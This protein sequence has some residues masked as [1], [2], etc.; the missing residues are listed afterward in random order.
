M[1]V[2][3]IP[4]RFGEGQRLIGVLSLPEQA[5]PG[6]P[7]LLVPN[8]GIEHRV[9]PNR[10]HVEGAR[11]L[12]AEGWT[13]LRVDLAGMGDSEPA[14]GR[15]ADAVSDLR[16]AA[17][18]IR[19]RGLG[20]RCIVLG[21]CSGAHDAH[22]FAL[23]DPRVVGVFLIDGYAYPTRRF[24]RIRLWQRL[25][26]VHRLLA[27]KLRPTAGMGK[28]KEMFYFSKPSHEQALADYSALLGRGVKLGLLFTGDVENEYNY[29]DQWNQAFPSLRGKA[30]VWLRPRMDHT[31]TRRANRVELLG[32]A[33]GWLA[34]FQ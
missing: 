32:L 8:T 17:D 4:L 1:A 14:P 15:G 22:Q 3:E 21:L 23:A 33:R 11:A 9:G 34:Q 19:A 16:A 18:L 30:Q 7:V 13:V 12:A 25:Q 10:L 26:R 28:P 6:A 29:A 5:R 31:L 2:K 27:E 24:F 20:E